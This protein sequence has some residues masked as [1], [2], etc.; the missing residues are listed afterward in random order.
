MEI[1]LK[2]QQLNYGDA[3]VRVL[4]LLGKT[5]AGR[6]DAVGKTIAAISELPERLIYDIFDAIPAEQ[7]NEIIACFVEEHR[8]SLLH[9][10]NKFSE[11][12]RLGVSVA[13]VA[14]NRELEIRAVVDRIDYKC[15]VER[16]LPKIREKMLNMG[17]VAA[18]LRPVI[19]SANADQ[20]CGLLERML[21]DTKD[22]FLVSLLNQNQ[23]VLI[24]L[25]EKSAE[26]QKIRMT[27]ASL[28]ILE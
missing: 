27:I 26:K 6:A 10:I 28:R 25:V 22:A 1:I 11:Q 9:A 16:F 18:F 17:V 2:I 3:A 13:D 14:V 20:I 4:P 5:A 12:H 21:G 15:I 24:D 7:K 23:L 19:Q 8:G